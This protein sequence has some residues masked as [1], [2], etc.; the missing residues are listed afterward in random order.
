MLII[1]YMHFFFLVSTY[2]KAHAAVNLWE[3]FSVRGVCVYKA[4][5]ENLLIVPLQ[6]Y[7]LVVVLEG[8]VSERTLRTNPA[9]ALLTVGSPEPDRSRG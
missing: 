7:L 5:L 6:W 8:L 3:M 2:L 4:H 9:V 1:T